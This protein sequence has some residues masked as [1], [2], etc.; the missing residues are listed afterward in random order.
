M[1]RQWD[2]AH[3]PLHCRDDDGNVVVR[4]SWLR[5]GPPRAVSPTY[6]DDEVDDDD[7]DDDDDVMMRRRRR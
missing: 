6:D 1:L 7:E 2:Q 3:I 4:F 5:E